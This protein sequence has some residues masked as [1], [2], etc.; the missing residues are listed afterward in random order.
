MRLRIIIAVLV[1]LSHSFTIPLTRVTFPLPE[2]PIR[3]V[4]QASLFAQLPG[5]VLENRSNV[6]T[7]QMQY[8]GRLYVGTPPK[9]FDLIFDTGSSWLWVTNSTCGRRCHRV[10]SAFD[11][12]NSSSYE[13]RGTLLSLEYGM[14]S[15]T[16]YLGFESVGIANVTVRRQSLVIVYRNTGFNGMRADGLLGLGFSQLADNNLTFVDNLYRQ[17]L[18]EA[19][20][21][22][23]YLS[24]NDFGR[25]AQE[26]HTSCITFGHSEL[27]RYSHSKE[28][29]YL[30]VYTSTGYWAVP[31]KTVRLDNTAIAG[32]SFLAILD[33]G[34]SLLIGPAAEVMAVFEY[35]VERW[36]CQLRGSL[37]ECQ[38]GNDTL[39]E[40]KFGLG[41]EG[42]EFVLQ[43]EFYTQRRNGSC[44]L[45]F[46][47]TQ[48]TGLWILG[49]VFL[50]AFYT[51]FD[52]QEGRVGLAPSLSNPVPIQRNAA[53]VPLVLLLLMLLALLGFAAG[54][55][56]CCHKHSL[57]NS[58][59]LLTEFNQP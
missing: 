4:T 2:G 57:R 10:G 14:G 19:P 42:A 46:D 16:G 18:I 36:T 39:P 43:P 26:A 37:L 51:V 40:L 58:D 53:P 59:P 29:L 25:N 56:L 9:A 12:R 47:S 11:A 31:L 50:R 54:A 44:V 32:S 8:R 49:D 48:D 27:S 23:I 3:P 34:T 17:G 24:N 45:L 55:M 33:T 5:Q 28:I 30:P 7:R 13:A 15:A 38:C 20:L 22:A 52:M 41:H 6:R 21:F 35:F 1:L